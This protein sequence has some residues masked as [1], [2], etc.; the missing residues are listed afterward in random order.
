MF[1]KAFSALEHI[2]KGPAGDPFETSRKIQDTPSVDRVVGERKRIREGSG[3]MRQ[4]VRGI[5]MFEPAITFSILALHSRVTVALI[6]VT[7]LNSIHHSY[8]CVGE[9]GLTTLVW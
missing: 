2:R 7:K 9:I 5:H 8:T 3:L 1:N 4:N 6:P